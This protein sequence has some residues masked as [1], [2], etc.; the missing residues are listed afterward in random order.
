MCAVSIELYMDVICVCDIPLSRGGYLKYGPPLT[1]A[2]RQEEQACNPPDESCAA[3]RQADRGPDDA[4]KGSNDSS[5][6]SNHEPLQ[7]GHVPYHLQILHLKNTWWKSIRP[8]WIHWQAPQT[9]KHRNRQTTRYSQEWTLF[10]EKR[11]QFT[12]FNKKR[13]QF[14]DD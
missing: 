4:G 8:A 7:R 3:P 14:F 10:K 9:S 11:L 5:H 12:F 1:S 6:R 13:L 2:K